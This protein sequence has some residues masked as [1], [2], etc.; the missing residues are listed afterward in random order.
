MLDG[1]PT[2][3]ISPKLQSNWEASH[4][5]AMDMVEFKAAERNALAR[6]YDFSELD[7]G[8]RGSGGPQYSSRRAASEACAGC[9]ALGA[10]KKLFAC[11]LCR[12]IWCAGPG[13]H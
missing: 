12:Q 10:A 5:Y 3:I 8:L 4:G 9:G 7:T 1:V 13:V 6:I 2:I 11:T